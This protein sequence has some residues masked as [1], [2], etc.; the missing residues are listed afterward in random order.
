MATGET[1]TDASRR[2]ALALDQAVLPIQGPPGTGKTWTGARMILALLAEGR[3]VG[4]TAQSHK[5]IANMLDAVLAAA[6]REGRTVRIAQRCDDGEGSPDPDVPCISK[7]AARTGLA[8]GTFEIVGGTP[9][10]WSRLEMEGVL[11]VLFVDEAGQVSLA[12]VC[13]VAGSA[14]SV[15]LL[16]DPN[17]LPQVS[18]GSHPEG[19]AASALEHLVGD[20]STI[21][22]DRGLLLTT[23]Y[24]MHPAVNAYISEIFYEGRLG[25]D[26]ANERQSVADG[27]PIGGVGLRFVGIDHRGA[28]NRSREEAEWVASAIEGLLGRTWTD[29]EGARRAIEPGDILVVAP[30]NAHVAEIG[31]V[32]QR[33]LG[34][35]PNAGTVDRFQ[36]REAPVAIYSMATSSLDDAPRDLEFLYS[37]NRLNVALSRA[38]GLSVLVAS[39]EL[40]LVACHTP[41]QMR[42]L[43]A[44][45][46]LLEITGSGTTRRTGVRAARVAAGVVGRPVD[47]GQP[48]SATDVAGP[49]LERP[50]PLTL[51]L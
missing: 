42:L 38:R 36:G 14:R 9:W 23:T 37:G 8:D 21:A 40:F 4:V 32:V 1:V 22:P 15:V 47:S 20:A 33:R 50:I 2:I 45:C 48:T 43:N 34:V 11:D 39:P 24:R 7:E 26:P 44:F 31:A 6:R 51:G 5:V 28:S 16:G 13:A 19:A 10:L 25:T 46:R 35:R 41:D 30:Y 27:R 17:Q 12:N 3:R 18:Q 49:E 29:R